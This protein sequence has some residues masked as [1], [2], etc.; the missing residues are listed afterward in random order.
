MS[1]VSPKKW[2]PQG[3]RQIH[4]HTAW[5]PQGHAHTHTHTASRASPRKWLPCIHSLSLSLSHTHT[6]VYRIYASICV[7]DICIRVYDTYLCVRVCL[8]IHTHKTHTHTHTHTHTQA[9][10]DGDRTKDC[11]FAETPRR[12]RRRGMLR[13]LLPRLATLPSQ[14]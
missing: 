6:H 2:L 5:P 14:R 8:C 9:E 13:W 11:W 3:H 12:P 10:E 1:R 4:T 7:Y